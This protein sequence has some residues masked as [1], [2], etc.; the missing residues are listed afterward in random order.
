MVAGDS[1]SRD[2]IEDEV[3]SIVYTPSI[4]MY[5]FDTRGFLF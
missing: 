1:A 3:A 4:C 2:D 5:F